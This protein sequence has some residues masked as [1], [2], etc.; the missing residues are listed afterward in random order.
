MKTKKNTNGTSHK[1]LW[2]G[3]GIFIVCILAADIGLRAYFRDSYNAGNTAHRALIG[4]S[5]VSV[6]AQKNEAIIFS[7]E[8]PRAGLIFYPGG[9]VEY[10]AYAPLMHA[11]AENGFLCILLHMPLNLAVLDPNAAEGYPEQYP[12]IDCWYIGGHSLGGAMAANYV[13]K[14]TDEY[15]GLILLAAYSTADLSGSDLDVLCIYGSNDGVLNLE[16][17]EACKKNLP[18]DFTEEVIDGGCHAFFGNYG[19]QKGDGVPAIT[20]DE[21]IQTTVDFICSFDNF[22]SE[23]DAYEL[24]QR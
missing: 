23:R 15:D 8:E 14:H 5:K 16:K 9:K 7:P 18:E 22:A 13:K 6:S 21:Q 4:D 2:I 19:A 17:Y 24:S 11:L 1:K 3:F 12:E 20:N 10:E